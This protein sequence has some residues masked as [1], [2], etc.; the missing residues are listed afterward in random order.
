[1]PLPSALL[2]YRVSESLSEDLFLTV[3]KGCAAHIE[4]QVRSLG[5]DLASARRILDFGCGCGRIL[6]WLVDMYP[7]A[8]FYGADVDSDAIL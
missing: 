7:D 5:N 6:R 4:S 2:R 1:M 3:G 8:E